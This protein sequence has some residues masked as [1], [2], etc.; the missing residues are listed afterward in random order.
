MIIDQ[1]PLLLG[2]ALLTD[3][4]P[5]ER[6]TTSYKAKLEQILGVAFSAIEPNFAGAYDSTA[7]YSVGD[8]V[9]YEHNLYVCNTDISTAEDWTAAHWTQ[10]DLA[11]ALKSLETEIDTKQDKI[12]ASGILKGNGSAVSAATLGS[13]YGARVFQFTLAAA[14]WSNNEQTI[15]SNWIQASGFVYLIEPVQASKAEYGSAG[16]YADDVSTQYQITF[17][18]TTTPTS[19]LAVNVCRIVSANNKTINIAGGGSSGGG[20]WTRVWTNPDPTADYPETTL[21]NQNWSAYSE[22]MITFI[23]DK[24][25]QSTWNVCYTAFF[26]LADM[27]GA[28]VTAWGVTDAGGTLGRRIVD[29]ISTSGLTFRAAGKMSGSGTVN[30]SK[31]VPVFIYAR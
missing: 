21:S 24:G 4:F 19:D 22:L 1:L 29:T 7:T 25:A 2:D 27:A 28:A 11:S 6:G 18:C 15:S 30:N 5:I 8:Y 17:H 23:R 3:E 10:I 14:D 26:N 9:V 12:T 31:L 13:D 16:I 20:A